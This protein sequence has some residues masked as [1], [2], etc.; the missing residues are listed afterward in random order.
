MT[1]GQ[2]V[3]IIVPGTNIGTPD[4]A[5]SEMDMVQQQY[6]NLGKEVSR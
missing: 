2:F 1:I 6:D 3:N 4:E 5:Q